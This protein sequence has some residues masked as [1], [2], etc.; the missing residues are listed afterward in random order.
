MNAGTERDQGPW[1]QWNNGGYTT[2][3]LAVCRLVSAKARA[4]R[5]NKRA[6]CTTENPWPCA[7][8]KC[9]KRGYVG[10]GDDLGC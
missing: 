10:D 2:G 4:A 9:I 5:D 1:K 7:N 6:G 3:G 8:G